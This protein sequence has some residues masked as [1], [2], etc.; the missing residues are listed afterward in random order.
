M[1]GLIGMAVLLSIEASCAFAA[2]SPPSQLIYA[3]ESSPEFTDLPASNDE[4]SSETESTDLP[5][6]T[7]VSPPTTTTVDPVKE[8][9]I[10][11]ELTSGGRSRD[12]V[13]RV[14]SLLA[15]SRAHLRGKMA[16]RKAL[17]SPKQKAEEA[18]EYAKL[19]KWEETRRQIHSQ[20]QA[21]QQQLGGQNKEVKRPSIPEINR[22]AGIDAYLYQGDIELT[23]QQ[24][25][26]ILDLPE[27]DKKAAGPVGPIRPVQLPSTEGKVGWNG[28]KS[29]QRPKRQVMNPVNNAWNLWPNGDIYYNFNSNV[30]STY[31]ALIK[32]AMA[33]WSGSTCLAFYENNTKT[34]TM[35]FNTAFPGCRAPIG[36]YQGTK[37]HTIELSAPGCMQIGTIAHEI[38]HN[39]GMFHTMSRDDR[40]DV[41]MIYEDNVDPDQLYNYNKTAAGVQQ[42]FGIPYDMGSV[43]H[44]DRRAFTKQPANEQT[45]TW[46]GPTYEWDQTMGSQNS[47]PGMQ[48]FKLI[49]A[50]YECEQYCEGLTTI[51][52]LN[53]GFVK[54]W[55]TGKCTTCICPPGVGGTQCQTP[56]AAAIAGGYAP[57]G[58]TNTCNGTRLTATTSWKTLNGVVGSATGAG[59]NGND[60]AYCHWWMQAPAGYHMVVEVTGINTNLFGQCVDGC[61]WGFTE[62]RMG[63]DASDWSLPGRRMCCEEDLQ[64]QFGGSLTFEAP[65][66]TGGREAMISVYA[67]LNRQAFTLKYKAVAN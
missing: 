31:R 62:V 65:S 50:L 54:P 34:Y 43:M 2:P 8:E 30:N 25:L 45:I 29:S 42:S 38:G 49:N 10:L 51:T 55:G 56:V 14:Q 52:C 3:D 60:Y 22:Q 46:S 40:D 48:D 41:V 19:K 1:S 39:I 12:E 28:P 63:N 37:T 13:K 35:E 67:S 59:L 57:P 6:S 17:R 7:T 47:M 36:L 24:A 61:A 11:R 27:A 58:V 26:Q 66:S 4:S 44:Y 20:N 21:R 33:T 15:K 32:K 16:Q 64:A 23:E 9:K 53:G 18:E 5:S